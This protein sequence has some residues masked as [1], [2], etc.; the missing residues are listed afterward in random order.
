MNDWSDHERLLQRQIPCELVEPGLL[1]ALRPW[2][3][4]VER[5]DLGR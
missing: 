5:S 4:G 2:D 1:E 3:L